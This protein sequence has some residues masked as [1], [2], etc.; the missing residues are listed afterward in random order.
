MPRSDSKPPSYV[1]TP[2]PATT[3][4]S[5][6]PVV[7]NASKNINDSKVTT[8]EPSAGYIKEIKVYDVNGKLRIDKMIAKKITGVQLNVSKL[9]SGIY[10]VQI[11]SQLSVSTQK[12]VIGQ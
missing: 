6:D 9:P 7:A 5:I 3:I 2:N 1:L 4:V 10:F 12:L 8:A 11:F